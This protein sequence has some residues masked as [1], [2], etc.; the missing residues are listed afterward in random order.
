MP[1]FMRFNLKGGARKRAIAT[2][3]VRGSS[4][5]LQSELD[6]ILQSLEPNSQAYVD[7]ERLMTRVMVI[8]FFDG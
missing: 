3:A 1:P 8:N 5:K 2:E 7:Y 4:E 6:A